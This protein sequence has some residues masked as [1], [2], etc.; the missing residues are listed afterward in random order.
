MKI[1]VL[2]EPSLDINSSLIV[3]IKKL[4][5][6]KGEKIEIIRAMP[7]DINKDKIDLLLTDKD[8]TDLLIVNNTDVKLPIYEYKSLPEYDKSYTYTSFKKQS[9]KRPYKYHK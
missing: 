8:K 7:D 9:W 6:K 1:I 2:G 4:E 3:A 5:E